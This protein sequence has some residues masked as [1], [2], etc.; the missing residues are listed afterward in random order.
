LE[1]KRD[2]VRKNKKK[3]KRLDALVVMMTDVYEFSQPNIP[4]AIQ[5]RKVQSEERSSTE[6]KT[7]AT[8]LPTSSGAGFRFEHKVR[9]S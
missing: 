2:S 3:G 7:A 5:G 1:T 6:V 8:C 9:S 4:S